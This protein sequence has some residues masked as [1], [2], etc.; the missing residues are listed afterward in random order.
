MKEK[1]ATPESFDA[2]RRSLLSKLWIGLGLVALGEVLWLIVTF[3]RPGPPRSAKNGIGAVVAAGPV[4]GFAAGSVTAFPRGRFYLACLEDSGFLAVSRKCTHLGCTVPWIEKE[5]KFV[6]PCH[7]SVFDITGSV[8]HAPAPRALD[9][10]R[11]FIENGIVNVDT[12]K[13]IKRSRFE[14]DQ[15][16]YPS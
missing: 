15:V 2:P 1:Q 3:F 11:V 5:M 16:T 14:K 8:I 13:R 10:Y 4:S 9:L 7:A 12:G 6:C